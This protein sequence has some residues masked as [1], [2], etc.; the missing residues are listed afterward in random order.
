MIRP[1]G[2]RGVLFGTALEGDARTLPGP[3]RR[4]S[5]RLGIPSSWAVVRQVHGARVLRVVEAGVQGEADAMVTTVPML[6]LAVATAD[7]FPVVLES[8]GATAIAHAGWRGVAEGVVEATR[9]A[10]E[11]IGLP[12][13]RAAVGPGIRACC[14][15]VGEDVARLFPGWERNTSWGAPSVDLAAAIRQALHP[16]EVWE[17]PECTMCGAGFFSYRRDRSDDR[18]VA[19]TWLPST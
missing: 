10:L 1:P 5:A 14:F 6:P 15:E 3:R 9:R 2:F 8:Q 4:L 13:D 18:Q 19:V 12:A 7:C 17:S 11:D 16:L